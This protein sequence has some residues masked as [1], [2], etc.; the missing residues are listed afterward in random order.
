MQYTLVEELLQPR[1]E[2]LSETGLSSWVYKQIQG[3]DRSE[4]PEFLHRLEH[5]KN[6]SEGHALIAD[7]TDSIDH[8]DKMM[9]DN[10]GRLLLRTLK[11]TAGTW[12]F[13][14]VSTVGIV[15]SGGIIAGMIGGISGVMAM[16]G[17]AHGLALGIKVA[18]VAA[19]LAPLIAKGAN[20]TA[21]DILHGLKKSYVA[22]IKETEKKMAKLD[23]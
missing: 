5:M 11:L 19:A 8:L 18:T 9:E 7:I 2:F 15:I 16:A 20:F 21:L 3:Y 4:L 22:L 17:I 1:D 14:T 13:T 10:V 23:Y 12:A 6:K